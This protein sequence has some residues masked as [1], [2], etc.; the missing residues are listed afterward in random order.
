M[1]FENLPEDG[2]K[3]FSRNPQFRNLPTDGADIHLFQFVV[4]DSSN[5]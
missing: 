1:S 3:Y 2:S 4:P 5:R